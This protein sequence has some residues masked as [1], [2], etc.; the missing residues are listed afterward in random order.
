M[1]YAPQDPDPMKLNDIEREIRRLSN[2][3]VGVTEDHAEVC[4]RRAGAEVAYK[5][6]HT[7]AW[8]NARFTDGTVPEKDAV[9]HRACYAEFEQFKLAE[10]EQRTLEE[11]GR[12]IRQQLSSLQTL[13]ANI[14]PL[15]THAGGEG[16]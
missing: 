6:A 16:W 9:V 1:T 2:K 3:L 12:N 10:A 7:E 8:L 11:S 5:R 14:R 13:A 4:V 15:V